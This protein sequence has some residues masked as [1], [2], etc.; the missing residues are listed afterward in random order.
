MSTAVRAILRWAADWVTG[1][2]AR[3]WNGTSA[4]AANRA[5]IAPWFRSFDYI[6]GL[7]LGAD[8]NDRAR[9]WSTDP[10]VTRMGHPKMVNTFEACLDQG[11]P[12]QV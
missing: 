5:N 7:S 8:S 1:A 3:D 11:K 9:A 2:A 6:S 12:V 10:V 4:A